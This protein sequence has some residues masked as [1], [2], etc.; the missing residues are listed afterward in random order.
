M[1]NEEE[2]IKIVLIGDEGVGKTSIISRYKNDTSIENMETSLGA[3]FCGKKI[4]IGDKTVLINIWDTAGQE[5]YHSISISFYRDAKIVCLVYDITNQDSFVNLKEKWLKDVQNYGEKNTILAV[6]GN[7]LDL[8]EKEQVIEEE[9]RE[10]AKEKNAI[11]KLTSAQSGAGINNLFESLIKK[12]LSLKFES[13]EK[14]KK[15]E[16]TQSFRLGIDKND[17]YYKKK[18][19]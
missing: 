8:Y 11:F 7:K 9:A 10:F 13:K 19:C 2:I 12:Y 1:S 15:N 3:S 14:E 5:K 4:Q 16:R 17:K 18:C 6:V